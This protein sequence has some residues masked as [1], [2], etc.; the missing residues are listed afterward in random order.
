MNI[1]LRQLAESEHERAERLADERLCEIE[2]EIEELE[3]ALR[4]A[5]IYRGA[6]IEQAIYDLRCEQ[7]GIRPPRILVDRGLA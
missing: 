4:D 2:A 3:H 1:P 7:L 5:G 6:H